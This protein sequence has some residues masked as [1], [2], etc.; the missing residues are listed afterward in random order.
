MCYHEKIDFDKM[1]LGELVEYFKDKKF[2]MYN[3]ND[4]SWNRAFARIRD[5]Y[6]DIRPNPQTG[7]GINHEETI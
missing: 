2:F 4:P 1:S 5:N 7:L 6:G 3:C